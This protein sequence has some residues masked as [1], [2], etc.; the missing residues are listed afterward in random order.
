[1][2]YR[3][4]P[5]SRRHK[6]PLLAF[7][8]SALRRCACRILYHSSPD[9]APFRIS[10]E[11]PDGERMGI[12]AYAFFANRK[13]TRNRPEDEHRFQVKYGPKTGELHPLWQDPLGLY[14]TLFF[15][16]NPERDFFVGADPSLHNPTRFFISIEFKESLVEVI[17]REGWH[18]WERQSHSR[19]GLDEPLEIMVGGKP[20]QFLRYVR[21]ERSAQGLDS[22]HRALLADKLAELERL[23]PAETEVS[24][25]G[26]VE[27]AA[28]LHQVAN[29]FQ[30]SQVEILDLIES[31]PRL[32]MA[33]RGW[34]A[35]VHLVRHLRELPTIT[36]CLPL[37]EDG[38]PDVQ[39]TLAGS[40][41][42]RIECKNILRRAYADG[43]LRIDFQRTRAAKGDPCS[44]YYAPDEFEVVAACL[45][46]RTERW[47][48]LY[49]LTR[50]M[51]PHNRCP[52]R[53]S[54]LA[55]IDDR[56][57]RDAVSVLKQAAA[58]AG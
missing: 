53:L 41:P 47:E 40:R 37:E 32:K 29:E 4:F 10:F 27:K 5:V 50:Q 23:R 14:T 34:V 43:N 44:R 46:P 30:L 57:S 31:A 11:A 36:E 33:V 25:L 15:G 51:E 9:E 20:E 12:V 45:H 21:F 17:E 56:W 52:G 3:R 24:A 18:S 16:I 58:P 28:G 55:R 42:I 13:T 7:I 35:E 6:E 22:G 2:S 49:T 1:M 39:V 26:T 8:L 48:F 38:R 19:E 54:N